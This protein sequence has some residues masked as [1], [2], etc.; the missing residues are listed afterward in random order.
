MKTFFVFIFETNTFKST[1]MPIFSNC[2]FGG[3][4]FLKIGYFGKQLLRLPFKST[5]FHEA[6]PRLNTRGISITF[7]TCLQILGTLSRFLNFVASVGLSITIIT[8]LCSCLCDCLE[9][10]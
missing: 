1:F 4:S 9:M 7:A 5:K 6:G 3:L 2:K 8:C 10:E